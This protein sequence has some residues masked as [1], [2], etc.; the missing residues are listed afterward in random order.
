MA[1]LSPIYNSAPFP[2]SVSDQARQVLSTGERQFKAF[3]QDRLL[4]QRTA[5]TEKISKKKFLC[6]AYGHQRAHW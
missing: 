4:M 6:E 2:Q 5:I 3:I 1:S